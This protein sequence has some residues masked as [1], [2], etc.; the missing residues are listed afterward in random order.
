[1][2]MEMLDGELFEHVAEVPAHFVG[3]FTGL[4]VRMISEGYLH[5]DPHPANIS[6]S[7]HAFS[8]LDWGEVVE[9]PK[10]HVEDAWVLLQ[11][12]V[13]GRW[14]GDE[15]DSLPA[16]LQ[17]LGLEVKRSCQDVQ[18]EHY[19]A[20][21]NLLNVVQVLRGDPEEANAGLIK[22]T[23]FRAPGWL[24]A[25]QKATN[26][27]AITLQAARATPEMVDAELRRV[28]RLPA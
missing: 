26:A 4:Y 5:Q 20:F 13:A 6:A 28:L 17:R 22:A 18:D 25:W 9:I 14:I 8:L 12:V 16:L 21:A 24:E 11:T 2:G 19:W 3:E 15:H 1:M 10:A 7:P 23:V 27:T